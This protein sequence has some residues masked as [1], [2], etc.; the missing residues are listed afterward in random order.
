[1]TLQSCVDKLFLD[2]KFNN[3]L[4]IN[5]NHVIMDRDA[6]ETML[7]WSIF[8]LKDLSIDIVVGLESQALILKCLADKLNV[9][10]GTIAYLDGVSNMVPIKEQFRISK[11]LKPNMK[12]LLVCDVLLYDELVIEGND[13]F[14]KGKRLLSLFGFTDVKC[15]SFVRIIP[16]FPDVP[17]DEDDI[18]STF[19]FYDDQKK[20]LLDKYIN[21]IVDEEIFENYKVERFYPMEHKNNDS[22]DVVVMYH[23]SME[24][25][26]ENFVSKHSNARL[27]SIIWKKFKDGTDNITFENEI[28]LRNKRIIYF[29]SLLDGDLFSQI[30]MMKVLPRQDIL[31]LDVYLAYFLTGTMERVDEFCENQLATADTLASM[32]STDVPGTKEGPVRLHIY[33]PHTLHNR[34]YFRDG[35]QLHMETGIELLKE[36]LDKD[37]IVV[38]PDDGAKKRF[39]GFFE[40]Y[41]IVSCNKVRNG[42]KRIINADEF[43]YLPLRVNRDKVIIVDDLVQTGG[44]VIECMKALKLKGVKSVS[45]YVTHVVFPE[46]SHLK[47]IDRGFSSS[48]YNSNEEFDVIY[49]T[50]SNKKI[51]DKIMN[52]PFK[53]HN[54][55]KVLEFETSISFPWLIKSSKEFHNVYVASNSKIKLS[56]VYDAYS[57]RSNCRVYGVSGID[58]CTYKQPIAEETVSGVFNRFNSLRD[59]LENK[60][61][62]SDCTFS[63]ESG[64]RLVD[65]KAVDYAHI[66]IDLHG[67]SSRSETS[68]TPFPI[69]YYYE[70]VSERAK[71]NDVTVGELLNRDYGYKHDSWQHRVGN[72]SRQ[73][74]I[75]EKISS[76][77]EK[78]F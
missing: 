38:F 23:P 21:P 45:V 64:I 31:S 59:Y 19:C 17:E 67:S 5:I 61:L 36:I 13:F 30:S 12:V 42:D 9:P 73:T 22:F 66:L 16:R 75:S 39:G 77:F 63:I 24:S 20:T 34:F 76:L 65:T 70:V 46:D 10:F 60:N 7:K 32:L 41:N 18:F 15:F 35:V 2:G 78:M 25:I 8:V 33:D 29:M 52:T 1:M 57:M 54:P 62:S 56:A 47:F 72:K 48:G 28:Y 49:H 71:G 51:S 69:E 14:K 4:M 68:E 40:D 50:N 58:S 53:K 37:V 26:A 11:N 44:T 55:F 27:G 74:L 43:D 6:F 3:K